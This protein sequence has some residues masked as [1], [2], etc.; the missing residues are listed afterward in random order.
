MNENGG[1]LMTIG[2]A[3]SLI[4]AVSISLPILMK[5]FPP[6]DIIVKIILIFVIITMVRGYLGSSVLTLIISGILIYF[7]ILKWWWVT[8]SIWFFTTLLTFGILSLFVWGTSKI[9]P[10]H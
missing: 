1:A 9:I 7:L 5:V 4:I 10:S 3:I 8:S 6:L 2:V